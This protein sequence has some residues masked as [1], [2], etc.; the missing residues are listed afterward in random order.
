MR[1]ESEIYMI[2]S[3]GIIGVME[4]ESVE[5]VQSMFLRYEKE[6]DESH[7]D[8]LKRHND[9]MDDIDRLQKNDT[10]S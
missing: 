4:K 6:L 5:D 2:K 8:F 10:L 1:G 3:K 9:L 7:K